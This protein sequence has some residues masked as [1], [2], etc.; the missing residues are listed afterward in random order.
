MANE[1]LQSE[2]NVKPGWKRPENWFTWGGL[3]LLGYGCLRGLDVIL[4]LLNRVLEN[5]LYT[6]LL[7]GALGIVL[8]VLTSNDVHRLAW[9]GYKMVMRKIT[10]AFFNI[11]PIAILK[12]YVESLKD[13]Y[14][15]L[16]QSMAS[17]KAQR[18]SLSD[19][20]KRKTDDYNNNMQ[21]MQQAE[22]RPDMK[23]EMRVRSRK[24]GRLQQ[25]AMT[26]QGLLNQLA[27]HIA[28]TEKIA[29]ASSF[30]IEDIQDTIAEETEKRNMV[31]ESYKAMSASKKILLA[32][33]DREVYDMALENIKDDYFKKLGEIEQFMQDSQSFIN[34]VDLQNGVYEEDALAKLKEWE[35]RSANLLEGGSGKTKFR[36]SAPALTQSEDVAVDHDEHEERRDS[37][38]DLFDKI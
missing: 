10:E 1:S 20:I 26:Y 11:D 8:W 38:A 16:K 30:M 31:R 22:K 17:L 19:L 6:G 5:L 21:L 36:V 3:A 24:A 37:Y 12:T 7:A 13:K 2:G 33:K 23:M 34:S 15:A 18:K 35:T 25:S 28:L 27:A 14:T 29:E 32:D 9:Y 4:P